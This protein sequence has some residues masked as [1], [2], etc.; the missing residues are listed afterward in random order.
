MVAGDVVAFYLVA[1]FTL[2]SALVVVTKHKLFQ[3]A[4]FLAMTLLGVAGLF[5]LAG[6]QFL[7]VIQILVYIGAIVTLILF[8]IMFT[9]GG[10]TREEG[11]Q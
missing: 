1:A 3:A 6:F 2:V 9:A 10:S 4:L 7:F 8:A 5:L 11:V